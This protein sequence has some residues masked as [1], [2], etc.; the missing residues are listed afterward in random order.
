M[1]IKGI[2]SKFTRGVIFLLILIILGLIVEFVE[3]SAE[4][5]LSLNSPLR[6]QIIMVIVIAIILV[7]GIFYFA[8]PAFND[9]IWWDSA[10]YLGM[11]KH[12]YSLGEVGLWESSRP[13]I[14]PLILGFLILYLKIL[15]PK[16]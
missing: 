16:V 2:V 14:W 9:D 3:F 7:S 12:I 13:L 15:Q 11:G 8:S 6:E 1:N 10:V 4:F 5:G